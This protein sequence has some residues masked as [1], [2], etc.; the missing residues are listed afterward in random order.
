[1][2]YVVEIAETAKETLSKLPP[3]TRRQIAKKIDMLAHNPR[4]ANCTRL[5]Q[6]TSKYRI[7]SGDYRIIYE[8]HD[9]KVVILVLMI[10]DRKDVYKHFFGR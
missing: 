5:T 6:D 8:I 3:K 9:K 1:M 10:G 7:R 4:P 2:T